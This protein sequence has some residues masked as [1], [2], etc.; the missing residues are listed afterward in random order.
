MTGTRV[1]CGKARHVIYSTMEIATGSFRNANIGLSVRARRSFISFNS[2]KGPGDRGR[3]EARARA[4]DRAPPAPC[5]RPRVHTPRADAP[6][7]SVCIFFI[8][9]RCAAAT[10]RLGAGSRRTRHT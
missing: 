10:H 7:R 9:D 2:S 3:L 6:R 4:A 5:A 8:S 1:Q